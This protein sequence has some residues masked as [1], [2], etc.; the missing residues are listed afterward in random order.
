MVFPKKSHW[1]LIFFLLSGKI[2]FLFPENMIL[3]PQ[4]GWWS[5]SKTIHR[6]MIF[7]SNVLKRL[8]FQ[9]GS[10]RDMIFLVLSEKVVFFS[11][12]HGIFFLG[13][14]WERGTFLKKY[15]ETWYFL[16]DMFHATHPHPFPPRKKNQRRSYPAKT[17]LKVI[18]IPDRH[19]RKNSRNYLHLHGD[20]YRRFH[21]LLSSKKT[22]K[23]LN[24]WDW[25]LTSSSIYSVGDVLQWIIFNKS[26]HSSL[27]SC[28][29]RCA[30]APTKEIICRLGDGL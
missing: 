16:F 26:Y 6:N 11:R 25:S 17:H 30:W 20:L 13:G 3:L 10:R 4:N 29:W 2:I 27:R 18:D 8:S 15:K 21:I 28:I 24:I 7:S 23:N 1:N 14:K 9:K 19:P 22:N 5:F 12:K